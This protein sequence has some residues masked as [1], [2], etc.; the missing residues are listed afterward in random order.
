MPLGSDRPVA[1]PQAA[2]SAQTPTAMHSSA[3]I[4][5]GTATF[6]GGPGFLYGAG[7]AVAGTVTEAPAGSCPGTGNGP[8][9]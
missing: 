8:A 5:T 6:G 7:C 1:V 4:S 3:T 9:V 2:I